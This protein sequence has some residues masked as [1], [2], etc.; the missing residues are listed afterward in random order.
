MKILAVPDKFIEHGE[1]NQLLDVLGLDAKGVANTIRC[2]LSDTK[3][4]QRAIDLESTLEKVVSK[5]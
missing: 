4:P 5:R 1:R 2:L 3:S